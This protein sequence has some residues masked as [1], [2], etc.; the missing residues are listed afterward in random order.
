[1]ASVENQRQSPTAASSIVPVHNPE[2]TVLAPRTCGQRKFAIA[3]RQ[4]GRNFAIEESEAEI[5]P[6]H[7]S[8]QQPY[9]AHAWPVAGSSS[10]LSHQIPNAS[11]AEPSPQIDTQAAESTERNCLSTVEEGEIE[12]FDSD[13]QRNERI[14]RR[15]SAGEEKDEALLDEVEKYDT[16]EAGIKN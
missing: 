2:R 12:S 5:L 14:S 1:M 16:Q 6:R 3:E 10:S 11:Q 15:P 4:R 8:G 7:N 13:F 9:V